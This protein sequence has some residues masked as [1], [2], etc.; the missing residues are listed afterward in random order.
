[1]TDPPSTG[2]QPMHAISPGDA[3]PLAAAVPAALRSAADYL[4]GEADRF[5]RECVGMARVKGL[6]WLHV[7]C[8]RT[9]VAGE[10]VRLAP[11]RYAVH[12]CPCFDDA[13]RIAD[14]VNEART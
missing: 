13:L 10:P 11:G 6:A 12:G 14:M 5:T 1:M 9:V 8:G 4:A 3:E 7:E 2:D